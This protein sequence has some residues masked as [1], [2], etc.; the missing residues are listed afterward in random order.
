MFGWLST[1]A[2]SLIRNNHINGFVR[3]CNNQVE[4]LSILNEVR[5]CRGGP[6]S[7]DLIK[8]V[9]EYILCGANSGIS[10]YRLKVLSSLDIGHALGVIAVGISRDDL[11]MLPNC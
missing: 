5:S 4:F 6:W 3:L 10:V 11:K 8:R 2:K 9:E 7:D 1:K